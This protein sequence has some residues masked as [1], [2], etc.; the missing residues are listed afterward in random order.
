MQFLCLLLILSPLPFASARPIWQLS[1]VLLMGITCV[2]YY[3]FFKSTDDRKLA[4]IFYLPV[5]ALLFGSFWG[6]LQ[7]LFGWSI[8]PESTVRTTIYLLSYVAFFLL[9]FL[10]IKGTSAVPMFFRFIGLIV[11]VYCLYGLI[12]YFTGNEKILWYD[13]W[14]FSQALS[15]T[16]VNRNSFA[17]YAGLGMNCLI[18]YSFWLFNVSTPKL[19][20]LKSKLLGF[21]ARHPH[22]VV[23]LS[24][25][26]IIVFTAILLTGSRAG[27]IS[28]AIAIIYL[29]LNLSFR[30]MG[31]REHIGNV[32][33]VSWALPIF[34][35]SFLAI[36]AFSGDMFKYRMNAGLE[37]DYR[38]KIYPVLM[39]IT[40]E[41]PL[42]GTGLGTFPEVFSAHRKPDLHRHVVR[43]HNDYLEILLTA[44]PLVGGLFIMLFSFF[45]VKLVFKRNMSFTVEVFS[46]CSVSIMLQ[47]A[48]HSSVDFPLQIPAIAIT[49]CGVMGATAVLW[50]EQRR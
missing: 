1:F 28:V 46:V 35:I 41:G 14:A 42:V 19:F 30:D 17:A 9:V 4:K 49:L 3:L 7:V 8:A 18:A 29:T 6:C 38:F 25:S 39:E 27:I 32:K 48:L 12:S 13:R 43:A 44:G 33:S 21:F 16:F 2:I 15:S 31:K 11:T 24:L 5:A 26:L 22:Q 37:N 20:G 36:F 34:F 23:I 40:Q 47:M 10:K 45:I 50:C